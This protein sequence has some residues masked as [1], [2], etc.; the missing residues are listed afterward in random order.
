M[1]KTKER[2]VTEVITLTYKHEPTGTNEN[3]KIG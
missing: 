3:K 2:K 1:Q